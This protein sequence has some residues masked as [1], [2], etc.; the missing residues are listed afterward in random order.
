MP[1]AAQLWRTNAAIEVL[2]PVP[3]TAPLGPVGS[4]MSKNNPS[5]DPRN[6]GFAQLGKLM[7]KQD[8]LEVKEVPMVEGSSNV[9]LYM[10]CKAAGAAKA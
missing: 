9:H 3:A 4:Q 8:Y 7:R 6:Y 10:R 2:P 1:V 5:F